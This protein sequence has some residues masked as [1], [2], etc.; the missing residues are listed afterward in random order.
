MTTNTIDAFTAP[1]DP[2]LA[3]L[4]TDAL[5]AY[6]QWHRSEDEMESQLRFGVKFTDGANDLAAWH[7][8]RRSPL[9]VTEREAQVWLDY[10]RKHLA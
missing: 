10:Y 9:S 2:E 5:A 7:R 3:A 8:E 4:V 6:R 1:A